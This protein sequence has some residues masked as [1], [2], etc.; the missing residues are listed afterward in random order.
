VFLM[1][2]VIPAISVTGV[3]LIR[4]EAGEPRPI[5][6]RLLGGGLAFGVAVLGWRSAMCLIRRN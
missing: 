6:W 4:S 2:L 3:L 1:G 5:D